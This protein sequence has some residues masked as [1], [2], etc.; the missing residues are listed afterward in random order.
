MAGLGKG[1]AGLAGAFG[2]GNKQQEQIA[3][4]QAKMN[5]DAIS[6]EEQRAQQALEEMLKRNRA[7][8]MA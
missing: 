4:M 3:Q 8:R 5:Q 2:G 1:L 6:Y 7:R